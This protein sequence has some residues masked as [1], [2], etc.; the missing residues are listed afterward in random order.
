MNESLNI[1]DFHQRLIDFKPERFHLSRCLAWYS[2]VLAIAE[3]ELMT[4][5]IN[6][7]RQ[8]GATR[9]QFYEV[10]LQSY[11]FLG[12][13]RMLLAAEN[14]NQIMPGRTA[15]TKT[16]VSVEKDYSTWY[17][18]GERLCQRIYGDAFESLKAK[19]QPMAPDIFDWMIIEGYGKVLSRPGLD[20]GIRE[21]SIVAFLIAENRPKQLWSHM[22]GA[23]N[24]GV[25]ME[26]LQ[27]VVTD[28]GV[29]VG[30]G[31]RSATE[32]IERLS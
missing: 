31:F 1:R 19:V 22:K 25:P 21:L 2:A 6:R 28:L 26:C 20:I 9:N 27:A 8:F 7:G 23:I 32:I 24:V 3:E 4:L 10:I 18:N 16:T 14:L 5:A 11:L 12:F 30:D 17:E 29:A 15:G 13:P